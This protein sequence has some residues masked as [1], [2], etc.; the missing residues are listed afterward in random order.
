VFESPGDCDG[1]YRGIRFLLR[2]YSNGDQVSER[3]RAAIAVLI[4]TGALFLVAAATAR[5]AGDYPVVYNMPAGWAASEVRETPPGSNDWSCRPNAAHPRPVVL[6][7]GLSGSAGR[8]YQA[9]SPLLA[10]NGYCVFAFDF[11]EDGFES[12][13]DS[14][15]GL[16]AFV[17]RVLAA[18]G[19]SQVD[20]VGHSQGGMMPRYYLKFLGGAP[21]VHALVGISPVNHGTTLFGVGTLLQ[22]NQTSSSAVA[23]ECP[24]CSEDVAGSDFMQ[25]LNAGGDTVPGVDYTVIGT[26]YEE[27]ITPYRSQFLVG[28]SVTNILLQDQCPTDYVDHLASI[29]DSVALHDMLNALDPSHATRPKCTVVLP[30]V[31]G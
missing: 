16:S 22:Q 6:V 28:S 21:K 5:A 9:G 10:N 15:V 30:G 11:S 2:L 8:D 1:F 13:E 26:R 18:T 19:A 12:N 24:A 31:G 20:L 23:G 14:A 4:A 7:P 3:L 29:Y 27:I 17:D 25:K